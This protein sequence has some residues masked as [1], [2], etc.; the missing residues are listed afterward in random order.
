MNKLILAAL[1]GM[2]LM[3]CSK[4]VPV[5][6]DFP[7][8]EK[9]ARLYMPQAARNPV[10]NKISITEKPDTLVYSAF[11]GGYN[12]A[13][14]DVGISF[15]VLPAAVDAYNL[16]NS[17][18]YSMMPEGS[19]NLG[20]PEAVIGAG[21]NST[22]PLNLII[23][24]KGFLE[25]FK[26]YMLPVKVKETGGKANV[27]EALST[28][29]FLITGSYAP[30][31]VPREK[32][33]SLGSTAGTFLIGFNDKLIRRDPGTGQ[34]LLYKPDEAGLFNTAPVTIGAGWGIFNLG[35][36]YG[37]DRLIARFKDGGQD[38]IQYPIDGNGTVG[39]GRVVGI[40]WSIFS[41]IVPY[42]GLLLGIDAAGNMTKYPLLPDG[43]FDYG[44]IA[45]IGSGWDKF[46]NIFPY[47]DGLIAV[48]ADGTMSLYPLSENGVFG[49]ETKV[50]TGWDMYINVIPV[51]TDLLGQ[52]AEGNLWRYKFNPAGLWP[53]K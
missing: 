25:P 8:V 3:A 22:G 17:T 36:F 38:V 48:T 41:K 14:N 15:S 37:G 5:K 20:Q 2:V 31:D 40:G 44:K 10:E 26:T 49:N 18:D 9:Y 39:A 13:A 42:K 21:T 51:G 12:P 43:S 19:Y 23:K 6:S 33:L 53:L 47:Q 34:L 11:L 1:T 24:S 29:Y 50:G 52:D 4:E 7:G 45:G 46:V 27:N 32:V 30:G 28:T 16:A 35:F